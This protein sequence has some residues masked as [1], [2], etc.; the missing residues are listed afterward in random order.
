MIGS[1][2][3]ASRIRNASVVYKK[4]EPTAF[5]S[6]PFGCGVDG[7]HIRHV[8]LER[9]RAGSDLG[10]S[11]LPSCKVSRPEEDGDAIGDEFL[12]DLKADTLISARDQGNT[13][14][15]HDTL[16]S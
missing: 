12:R 4:V 1:Y 14:V 15:T 6:D 9:V 8:N 2:S 11:G 10:S 7:H 13:I 5:R 3:V 16:P